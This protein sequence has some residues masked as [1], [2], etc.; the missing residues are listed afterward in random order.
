M[1]KGDP[2]HIKPENKGKLRGRNAHES[3]ERK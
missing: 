1:A 3:G 2:I